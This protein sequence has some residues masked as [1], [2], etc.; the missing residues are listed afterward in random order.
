M[1]KNTRTA[2]NKALDNESSHITTGRKG[3]AN[4]TT[5]ATVKEILK[6][7]TP[8]W[9]TRPEDYKA[10]AKEAYA[11]SK[12][13]SDAQVAGYQMDDQIILTDA[14]LSMVNPMSA[15]QFIA[16]LRANGL[17]CGSVESPMHNGTASLVAVVP[18][19]QGSKP[20]F[21]NSIQVPWMYEWSLMKLDDHNLPNGYRYVGW[22]DAVAQ[23]VELGIWTEQKA[24]KVF[25]APSDCS[26][27][28]SRYR[29][30]LWLHRNK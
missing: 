20:K 18:T 2:I 17:Q 9:V 22:R 3:M 8:D 24:H 10:F 29:R 14:A 30:S 27:R 16:K 21:V 1:I 13:R 19:T 4:A 5:E 12:E 11:A 15:K 23:L 28:S 7:G 6:H 25:G 26:A